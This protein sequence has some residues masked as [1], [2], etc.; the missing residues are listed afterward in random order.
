MK[1]KEELNALKEEYES[2]GRKLSE[3][4]EDELTNVTGGG[5][6]LSGVRMKCDSCPCEIVWA[7]CDDLKKNY[8]CPLCGAETFHAI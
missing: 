2:L 3:L 8:V 5:R 1:T 4:S 7:E 6:F